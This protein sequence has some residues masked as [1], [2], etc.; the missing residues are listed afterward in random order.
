M[1]HLPARLITIPPSTGV[2]LCR[3]VLDHYE[4]KYREERHAPLLHL[5][6]QY[7][8]R[9]PDYPIFIQGDLL[10]AV[11]RAIGDYFETRVSPELKLYPDDPK[12]MAQ[13]E[14]LWSDT[15]DTM[16][17]AAR[18]WIYYYLLPHKRALFRPLTEGVPFWEKAVVWTFYPIYRWLMYKGMK[19]S[20]AAMQ[21]DLAT[22]DRI[23]TEIDK[24]LSD[25]REFLVGDR[26][27]LA[28]ITFAT[29]AVP[30]TFPKEFK[31]ALPEFSELDPEVIKVIEEY[32]R[33]PAG[34]FALRMFREYRDK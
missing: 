16:G 3:W 19:L 4:V 30:V 10:M 7:W 24:L 32:R 1:S 13:I 28:D 18:T 12:L 21:D 8:Y 2:E 22:T 9:V 6:E 26:F 31:G 34:Q 29:M 11:T 25:G 33:R 27:T 15:H 23:F 17:Y 14:K 5:I 20:E